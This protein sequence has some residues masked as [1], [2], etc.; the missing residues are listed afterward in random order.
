M[1]LGYFRDPYLQHFV[2]RAAKRAPLINRGVSVQ[3]SIS[4]ASAT[5]PCL[6]ASRCHA[7]YY[8]RFAAFQQLIQSFIQR[9][10]QG[11]SHRKTQ[12]VSL[13]AG[14]DT[15]YFNLQVGCFI[16]H[17]SILHHA[18]QTTA[19]DTSW[20]AGGRASAQLLL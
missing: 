2:R 8:A 16:L 12:V 15:T 11:D 17:V 7:G 4:R 3:L 19:A 13:G 6:S 5:Y 20:L 18:L 10:R 9:C 1:K 14:F